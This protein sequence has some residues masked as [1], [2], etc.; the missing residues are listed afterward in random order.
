MHLAGTLFLSHD[1]LG[2]LLT[3]PVICR[4]YRSRESASHSAELFPLP[5]GECARARPF[6]ALFFFFSCSINLSLQPDVGRVSYIPNTKNNHFSVTGDGGC[7]EGMAGSSGGGGTKGVGGWWG[8]FQLAGIR[9]NS[10]HSSRGGA[11]GRKEALC[12]IYIFCLKTHISHRMSSACLCSCWAQIAIIYLGS[13]GWKLFLSEL[14][15]MR[16]KFKE[17]ILKAEVAKGH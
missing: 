3:Q 1:T 10:S 9:F 11:M 5:C 6:A 15:R 16:D 12:P 8:L 14:F 17:T 2:P 4:P 13:W 7:L